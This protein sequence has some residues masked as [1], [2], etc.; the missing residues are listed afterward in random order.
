[1]TARVAGKGLASLIPQRGSAAVRPAQVP[2]A[3]TAPI[4]TQ[5]A[6]VPE[7]VIHQVPVS[8]IDTNPYQP[9]QVIDHVSLDDLIRSIR[10]HGILQPLIVSENDGRYQLIAGER[11]FQSAKIIG[12]KTVPAIIRNPG[13]QEKLELALVENIQRKD[14]DPMEKAKGYRRLMDEFNLTQE[15]VARRVGKG[16]VSVAQSLRLLSLPAEIQQSIAAGEISEGHGKVLLA[17][18]DAKAQLRAWQQIKTQGL[19]VRQSES[20]GRVRATSRTQRGRNDAVTIDAEDQL[21]QYLGTRVRIKQRGR[22]GTIVI[23][24]FSPEERHG[25][26]K[27]IIKK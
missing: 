8:T 23:E 15:D 14:L 18:P 12:L 9:R 6:A 2:T 19:T 25:I 26:I 10:Q 16:R 5:S 11:R 21:Q 17:L 27:K 20:V 7:G 13:N 22:K 4:P 1:M 3:T 24:F